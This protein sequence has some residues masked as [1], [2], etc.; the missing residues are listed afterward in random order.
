MR[1]GDRASATL[2]KWEAPGLIP[3]TF[4]ESMNEWMVNE[5]T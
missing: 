5:Y 3:D 4:N 1:L 2:G